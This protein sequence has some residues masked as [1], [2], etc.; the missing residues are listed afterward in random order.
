M[1]VNALQ[2]RSSFFHCV[3]LWNDADVAAGCSLRLLRV[4]VAHSGNSEPCYHHCFFVLL[5]FGAADVVRS[6]TATVTAGGD[7]MLIPRWAV[8]EVELM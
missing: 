3:A 6:N 1:G 2:V 7:L 5:Q 8:K 4:S